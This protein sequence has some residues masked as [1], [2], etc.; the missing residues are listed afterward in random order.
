MH[1]LAPALHN[2]VEFYMLVL[3]YAVAALASSLVLP[4]V[5]R[6]YERTS[7]TVDSATASSIY[8]A[9]EQQAI[10]RLH[11]RYARRH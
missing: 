3:G 8:T 1:D 2:L 7:P 6:W 5:A 10:A 9:E 4:L 11:L